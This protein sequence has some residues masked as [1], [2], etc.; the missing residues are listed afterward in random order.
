MPHP[1]IL[2]AIF[3]GKTLY[4]IWRLWKQLHPK[5]EKPQEGD[6]ILLDNTWIIFRRGGWIRDPDQK[7]GPLP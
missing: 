2:G 1:V 7:S 4:R 3:A 6:R 5:D